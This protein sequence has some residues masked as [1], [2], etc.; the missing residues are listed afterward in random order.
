MNENCKKKK[1]SKPNLKSCRH[2]NLKD[3]YATSPPTLLPPKKE[4]GG[5]EEGREEVK[6][7]SPIANHC[8][9]PLT[10]SFT[11]NHHW[12]GCLVCTRSREFQKQLYSV[13]IMPSPVSD[14]KVQSPCPKTSERIGTKM[15]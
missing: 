13:G 11:G 7:K 6:A 3:T 10:L 4:E 5:K 12:T 1:K 15:Y 14:P 2:L 8:R 9:M